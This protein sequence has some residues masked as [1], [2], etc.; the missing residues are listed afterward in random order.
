MGS[1]EETRGARRLQVVGKGSMSRAIPIEVAIEEVLDAHLATRRGRFERHDLDHPATSL[2]VDDRGRR[3]SVDQVKYLIERVYIRA[4]PPPLGRPRARSR[5][6]LR[7]GLYVSG[8]IL[9]VRPG[10]S[11]LPQPVPAHRRRARRP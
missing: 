9:C 4:G 3:L 2:F 6:E 10:V 8:A 1:L 11:V 7:D 5:R